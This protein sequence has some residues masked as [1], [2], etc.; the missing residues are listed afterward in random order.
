MSANG[1]REAFGFEHVQE[2]RLGMRL[3]AFY[4]RAIADPA[5][6]AR[7]TF[8]GAA[9]DATALTAGDD[10]GGVRRHHRVVPELLGPLRRVGQVDLDQRRFELRAGGQTYRAEVVRRGQERRDP[11]GQL[12][13]GAAHLNDRRCGEPGRETECERARPA[14]AFTPDA[15]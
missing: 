7:A 3:P 2:R 11:F 10:P 14:P 13:R 9:S 12:A 8:R 1:G 6:G 15:A 4:S 5:W